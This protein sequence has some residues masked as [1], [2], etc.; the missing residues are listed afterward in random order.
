MEGT[1]SDTLASTRVAVLLVSADFLA[2]EFIVT[3]EL[4]PLLTAAEH[5][6]ARIIPVVVKPSRFLREPEI[7]KFQAL[8][9]PT[10]PLIKLPE[11][12]REE[13][14]A[15]LAELIEAEASS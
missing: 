13:L 4:P 5:E 8:N 9:D 10:R 14:Y 15:K 11:V 6:G 2:S 1:N 12:E 7:A 3:N